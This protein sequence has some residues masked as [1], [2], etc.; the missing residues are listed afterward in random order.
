[1]S[2]STTKLSQLKWSDSDDRM[3]FDGQRQR[4]SLQEQRT[5][6]EAIDRTLEELAVDF[7][8]FCGRLSALNRQPR[9]LPD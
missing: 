2:R 8:T 5:F 9:R 3:D 4:H 7:P 6:E 1:M